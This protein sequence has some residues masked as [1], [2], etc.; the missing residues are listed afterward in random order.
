MRTSAD[1]GTEKKSYYTIAAFKR[2]ALKSPPPRIKTNYAFS[3]KELETIL[4]QPDIHLLSFVQ[5]E[6]LEKLFSTYS[7]IACS[8]SRTFDYAVLQ[9]E[10]VG[11]RLMITGFTCMLGTDVIDSPNR[12]IKS[13]TENFM[14]DLEK[15]EVRFEQDFYEALNSIKNILR[16][17][18]LL[19]PPR[20]KWAKEMAALDNRSEDVTTTINALQRGKEG[21]K[22]YLAITQKAISG[23]AIPR[24]DIQTLD[25]ASNF[26]QQLQTEMAS[27]VELQSKLIK[28]YQAVEEKM[29]RA[30][31]K[32]AL[33]THGQFSKQQQGSNPVQK[34]PAPGRDKG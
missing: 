4:R 31:N 23:E 3:A 32:A 5:E 16:P 30:Q 14:I 12:E 34:R 7:G 28:V 6:N 11:I 21:I 18:D 15:V 13:V 2:G 25:R 8:T 24:D 22:A 17:A 26:L 20:I 27:D 33:Q 1:T 29:N 10:Q 19:Y 9:V